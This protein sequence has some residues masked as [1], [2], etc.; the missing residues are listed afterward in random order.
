MHLGIKMRPQ[1]RFHLPLFFR[2]VRTAAKE[3]THIP[4]ELWDTLV[5]GQP[6]WTSS[7]WRS[8]FATGLAP[9]TQRTHMYKSGKEQYLKFCKQPPTGV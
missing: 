2:Q 8:Q 1:M 5:T 3:P 7:S 6:N 4:Q 9:S